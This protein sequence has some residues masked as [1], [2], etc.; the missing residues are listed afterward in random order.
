MKYG[1]A[2]VSTD[3]QKADLQQAALKKDG[4]KKIFT[5]DG[6]SGATTKRPALLRCIKALKHGDTLTVWKLDRLGRSLRDLITMLDDFRDRGV[7]FRSLT[8]QI[9][10]HTPTGRAMWQMIGVLAEL[11]RSMISERTK[12]G[13]VSARAR[14]VKFGRKP[15]LTRQQIAQARK[16]IATGERPEDVAV[17][18]KVGR[19]TLYRALA[20]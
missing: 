16:L 19:T 10:S 2:R 15:K 3:D 6:I 12:A 18:F 8:E 1:Y 14:G 9:D 17:S 5:D 11:E 20:L 7:T 4:C 13:V